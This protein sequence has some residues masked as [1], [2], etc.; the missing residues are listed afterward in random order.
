MIS[1][2]LQERKSAFEPASGCTKGGK[3]HTKPCHNALAE[4][5]HAC[6]AAAGIAEEGQRH[7]SDQFVG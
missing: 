2:W 6:I 3:H 4:A 7:A 1:R 5:L